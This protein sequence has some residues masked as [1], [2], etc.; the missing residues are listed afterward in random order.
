MLI[1]LSILTLQI[2]IDAL[3]DGFR[4]KGVSVLSHIC[5]SIQLVLCSILLYLFNTLYFQEW[6]L[7]ITF[8]VTMR[9]VFFDAVFNLTS[10]L[11]IGYIGHSSLYDKFWQL[12]DKV[13]LSSATSAALTFKI[14]I[15][16]PLLIITI[17]KLI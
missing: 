3:G 10:G 4:Y 7:L 17:I 15:A 12:F 6:L 9:F 2:I 13:G 1:I 8:Y 11:Y 16:L 5:E 14:L